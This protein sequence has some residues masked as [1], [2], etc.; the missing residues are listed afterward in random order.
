[1]RRESNKEFDEPRLLLTRERNLT[2]H[3]AHE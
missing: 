3:I 1:L 2:H